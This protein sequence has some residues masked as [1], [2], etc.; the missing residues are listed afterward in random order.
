MRVGAN[1][2]RGA[3]CE[4]LTESRSVLH[5]VLNCAMS[6]AHSGSYS[7]A[8]IRSRVHA[9][10]SFSVVLS[11]ANK[12]AGSNVGHNGALDLSCVGIPM[13]TRAVNNM[14]H[15]DTCAPAYCSTTSR[16]CLLLY[17][18]TRPVRSSMDAIGARCEHHRARLCQQV[19][20]EESQVDCRCLRLMAGTEMCVLC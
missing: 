9:R 1:V 17:S 7:F 8:V 19:R 4:R 20:F 14:V 10:S 13:R 6:F 16:S 15:T 5:S 18:L 2:R 11:M 3:C 12:S